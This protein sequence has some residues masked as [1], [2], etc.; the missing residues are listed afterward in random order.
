MLENAVPIGET[1]APSA[2][3]RRE[4]SFLDVSVPVGICKHCGQGLDQGDFAA[5]CCGH[6]PAEVDPIEYD[7]IDGYVPLD[8]LKAIPVEDGPD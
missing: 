2:G 4:S 5:G 1:E 6:Q 3:Q 8:T 7:G